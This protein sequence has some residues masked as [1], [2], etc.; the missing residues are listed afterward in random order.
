MPTA[1]IHNDRYYETMPSSKP[2][3]GAFSEAPVSSILS[4][5]SP[6]MLLRT[7]R[8]LLLNALSQPF[9]TESRYELSH[10]KDVLKHIDFRTVKRAAMIGAINPFLKVFKE[11]KEITLHV[12]DKKEHSLKGSD[13]AYYLPSEM[14][15]HT[16]PLCDTV[17]ITGAA[18]ANGT[19]EELLT[20]TNPQS[21]VIVTGPTAGFIPEALFQRG[22]AVVGATVLSNVDRALTL[23][24]EG[25]GAYHLFRASCLRKVNILKPENKTPTVRP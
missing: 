17:I 15:A 8:L 20:Y 4:I 11:H 5:E 16:L 6:S 25:A 12:I 13:R 3:P 23:L 7:V 2:G 24:A 10:D 14:S 21:T 9:L 19:I 22:V 1:E 18:V